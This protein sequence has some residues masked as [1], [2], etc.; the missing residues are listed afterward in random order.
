MAR[1]SALLVVC[2][3][4]ALLLL[5]AAGAERRRRKRKRSGE[6]ILVSRGSSS[7]WDCKDEDLQA[8]LDET[9]ETGSALS[10]IECER[11]GRRKLR[12]LVAYKDFPAAALSTLHMKCKFGK[13]WKLV[14]QQG[15]DR[16]VDPCEDDNLEV[17]DAGDTTPVFHTI[18]DVQLWF[19]A[20][21]LSGIPGGTLLRP[22]DSP[23]AGLLCNNDWF[24]IEVPDKGIL[25]MT[26]LSSSGTDG[27]P[28]L[29][30]FQ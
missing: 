8:Y 18:S 10:V 28:H 9:T 14:K 27:A 22:G 29:W 11:A 5:P 17:N 1:I 13:G 20:P 25:I 26:V 7:R 24:T 4:T 15:P 21:P 23:V 3:M 30:V 2:V 16:P 19:L 6:V 12:C